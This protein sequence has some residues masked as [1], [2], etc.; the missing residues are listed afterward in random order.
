MPEFFGTNIQETEKFVSK[1]DQL[2]DLL[3]QNVDSK[4]ETIFLN[5]VFR[6]LS[7]SVY[8]TMNTSKSD[9]S[10]YANFKIFIKAHYGGQLNAFQ[11]VSR[12]FDINYNPEAKFHIYSSKLAEEVRNAKGA[13]EAHFKDVNK[14]GSELSAD[15]VLDFFGALIFTE[16]LKK[17]HFHIFKDITLDF[18][19]LKDCNAVATKAEYFRERLSGNPVNENSFFTRNKKNEKHES[20]ASR[21]PKAKK[22]NNKP[23]LNNRDLKKHPAEKNEKVEQHRD[24]G[25][26]PTHFVENSFSVLVLLFY[27]DRK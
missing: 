13:I 11:C 12:I 21:F 7:E 1:L 17:S 8:K 20:N 2:F 10:T 25:G 16:E 19:K 4:Y 22:G 27:N 18:D 9:V 24:S 5:N 6:R 26:Q 23:I 14:A 15:Q 3:V